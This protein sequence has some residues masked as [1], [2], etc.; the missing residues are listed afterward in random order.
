MSSKRSQRRKLK[1]E[2][3]IIAHDCI[4]FGQ[5]STLKL[6]ETLPELFDNSPVLIQPL[7]NI[8]SLSNLTVIDQSMYNTSTKFK[9]NYTEV[10]I[11]D[12]DER[13]N[14]LFRDEL[15]SWITSFNISRNAS[16]TLLKILKKHHCFQDLPCDSRTLLKTNV[17]SLNIREVNPG[18]YY[19]FVWVKEYKHIMHRI[20]LMK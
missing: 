5:N 7:N 16:D 1:E 6:S 12:I 2:L 15:A 19:H 10:E 8:S 13:L 11:P 9:T 20:I 3:D 14:P 18:I 17:S 4:S